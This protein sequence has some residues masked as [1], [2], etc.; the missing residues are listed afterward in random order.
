VMPFKQTSAICEC[1]LERIWRGGMTKAVHP[2]H[3]EVIK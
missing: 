3:L 1:G 2:E